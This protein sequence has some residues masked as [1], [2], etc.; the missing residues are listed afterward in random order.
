MYINPFWAGVLATISAELA[1]M[2]ISSV[3]IIIR[4][5]NK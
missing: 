2:F 3:L 5:A 4:R 1:L